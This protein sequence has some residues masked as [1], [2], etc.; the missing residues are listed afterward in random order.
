MTERWRIGLHSQRQRIWL[1][2]P[3]DTRIIKQLKDHVPGGRWDADEKLWH[4]P[5]DMEVARDIR[6]VARRFGTSLA[7]EPELVK[8]VKK[9]KARIASI[10]K[11]DDIKS[12]AS[13]LLPYCRQNYPNLI[14]AMTEKPWQ[15]PGAAF[16]TEQKNVLI[17]DQPG[18]GKTLQTL[19]AV[20]ELD[21]QGPIL[22]IAPRS[23]VGITWPE[24]I[25]QWLGPKERVVKI[26]TEL[27]PTERCAAIGSI[28]PF[29]RTWVLCG[30]NYIR[31]RADV[32]QYGNYERD[33]K[34]KK[35]IRVVNEAIPELF[36][37]TWSAIIVDESHQTLACSRG[38]KKKWSAQR[39]GLSA[40]STVKAGGLRI[41]I[42]GTP[43]RGKTENMWGTLNWLQP[44]KYTSYWNWVRRHYG[45]IDSY[46]AF[47]SG[48]VKGDSLIDEKRFYHELKP[49][50]IRRTKSEVAKDLP[51]K[52]YGGVRLDS[53]DETSPVAVWLPMT[54][55]QQKQYDQI[56]K[57]AVLSFDNDEISVDGILAEMVRFK[58]IANAAL[59]DEAY[60]VLPSN[61]SDW[62][63]DFLHRKYCRD[64]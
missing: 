57:E 61:K 45:I 27:K 62:I 3:Y 10:I 19:A 2:F 28:N 7:V 18:L 29:T 59:D 52:T 21:I 12:D 23:A 34:G 4:Y 32:D 51:P 36:N 8:W 44:T 43:M 9:E 64:I 26:N 37:I 31:I 25:A 38:D 17:A 5:L 55:K 35:I 30:P 24:E 49:L 16:I 63:V 1:T 42:S 54:K 11:P 6:I 13:H 33:A 14:K 53:D 56:V 58:Q 39:L 41:A 20:V 15:I 60:P 22:V 50:M 47:G 48:V 46:S 40:L